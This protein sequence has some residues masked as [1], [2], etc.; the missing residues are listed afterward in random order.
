MAAPVKKDEELELDVESLAYGGNG[1][2]RT[3]GFV[4]FVRRGLPGDRV[5]ARVTKV[6]RSHAE[7]LADRRPR[8]GAAARRGAVRALP[9]VRRLPLPGSRV[10]ARS[11]RRSRRRCATRSSASR[12][13]A[14]PPLEAIVPCEPEIFHYRNKMEYSFA[15]TP[16]GAAL[17]FHKAGRWDEVLDIEKCWLTTDSATAI[18]DAVRDWAREEGLEPYSQADNTRLPPPPRRPRGAQHRA[19]ARPARDRAGR[20]VRARLLRRRPAAS[21]RRCA[22]C[23]G[24]ST[25][26]RPR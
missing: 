18:R 2:A 11:S 26:R 12:G 15:Q 4:V 16:S 25:T 5:R 10:R 9:R 6:K 14:E 8:A 3:N 17:G 13:I 1:V 20:E 23:T 22:R 7:A 21:S 24:R 19:G